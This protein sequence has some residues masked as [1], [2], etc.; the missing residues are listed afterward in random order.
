[1][2]ERAGPPPG[3]GHEP[4]RWRER[5]IEFLIAVGGLVGMNRVR[6]RWRLTRALDRLAAS[7]ARTVTTSAHVAYAH[8]TCPA[9]GAVNDRERR[10]CASCGARL[11]SRASQML[12]RLGLVVPN[13]LSVPTL[14]STLIFL[15]YLRTLQLDQAGGLMGFSSEALVRHG[16]QVPAL[17]AEGQWWRLGSAVLLHSSIL[18]LGF[19]LLAL[20]MIGPPIEQLF[21]R[22]R[23]LSFFMATGVLASVA[24][25]GGDRRLG[26]HHGP[27]R[28]G[29]RLGPARRHLGRAPYAQPHVAVGALH[30]GVWLCHRGQ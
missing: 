7:I 1:M 17:V 5:L 23:T 2:G 15:I 27:D 4:G 8:K 24:S 29:R 10:A 19:N 30:D 16:G 18:H 11:G 20:S 26:R 12:A 13:V 14:L 28:C 21:G 25:V 9:C 6:L 22:L 3:V